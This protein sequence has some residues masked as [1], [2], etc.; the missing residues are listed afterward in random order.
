MQR[1]TYTTLLVMLQRTVQNRFTYFIFYADR[2]ICSTR[3]GGKGVV[4]Y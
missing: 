2:H 1:P 3:T 4:Y